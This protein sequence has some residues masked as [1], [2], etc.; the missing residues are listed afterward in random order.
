MVADFCKLSW[1]YMCLDYTILHKNLINSLYMLT[2]LYSQYR[3]ALLYVLA[4]KST[5]SGS[6]GRGKGKVHPI[7]SHKGQRGGGLRYGSTL[8]LTAALDGFW[9][10]PSPGRFTPVNE[11]RYP[12]YR[13]LGGPQGQ[14]GQVQKISPPSGIWSPDRPTR[15]EYWYS[16][17]AEYWYSL[18]AALTEYVSRCKCQI[19]EH[20]VVCYVAV[21]KKNM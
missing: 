16:L 4:L 8:S 17:W 14:L 9:W 11:T 5:S 1:P 19:K 13:R 2:P 20:R 3:P 12:L 15:R 21:V 18:W 7:T 10:S 6:K